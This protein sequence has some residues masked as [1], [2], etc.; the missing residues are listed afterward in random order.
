[1]DYDKPKKGKMAHREI[2]ELFHDAWEA[3]SDNREDAYDDLRFL[4]GDQ[5]DSRA[6]AER[7]LYRRPILTI[8]RLGQFVRQVTG[9]MRL[10]PTSINVQP[11][12]DFADIDKAEIFEGIIRQIEHS[13]NATNAYAHAFECEAGVGIGHFRIV[14]QYVDNSVDEQEIRIKRI[15]NPLAVTWDPNSQEIDR[16]DA[17]FCFVSDLM[18]KRAFKKKYPGKE[19]NDFPRD[20]LFND[21]FWMSGDYVRVAEFWHREPY[22]RTL[23]IANDGS[24]LDITVL[25]K[26]QISFLGLAVDQDGKPR[27]R[28]FTDY[29]IKQYIV[30]GGEILTGPN[31]WAGRHI[32]VVPAIG[33]EIPLDEQVIRH[34]IIRAAKDP[35]RLYNYYRSSQAELIGQQPRAPFLMTAEQIKGFEAQWNTANT[36]PRPYLLFNP[37]PKVG[38]RSPERV[39][40]PAASAP[41]WQEAALASDDMKATTGI[42]DAALGARSNET[43]GKAILARQREG[44]VGSY[45]Y[46]DNFKAAIKRAGDI[47]IDLI[48]RIYDTDR[49]VRIIGAEDDQPKPVR[50]NAN[51]EGLNEVLNDL[52]IGKFD[53]RVQAGPSFSTKR[54]EARESMLAATQAN[55]ALWGIA[56][57]LI[58]KAMDW[59]YAQ[60]IAER[61]KRSLPPQITASKEELEAMKNE[62]QP[63]APPDPKA[64]AAMA[65]AENDAKRLELD[66]LEI[67]GDQ[68]LK[69]EDMAL[70]A[71]LKREALEVDAAKFDIANSVD[72]TKFEAQQQQAANQP[73]G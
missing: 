2:I 27:K 22:E 73:Q 53:V 63:E 44:D 11:V 36:N 33:S 51:I 21:L 9:D 58:V 57:D 14:T 60:E 40:P 66:A 65:K 13:S 49:I 43:S 42:Y 12:D 18:S 8:N 59:P 32:P 15:M 54:E 19:C 71:D 62:P 35:Q 26:D 56:G 46:F 17:E 3:D 70:Q 50:V 20:E 31:E 34:G 69:R 28:T 55:P 1:M 37:D 64:I 41:L 48:P 4:S 52:T 38:N 39:Q 6:K 23:A 7:E 61:I 5:W 72:F 29:R 68:E 67:E 24:T 10:N 47:L 16:S 45:H 25:S 30:S